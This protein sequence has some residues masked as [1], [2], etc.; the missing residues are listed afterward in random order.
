[1]DRPAQDEERLSAEVV[2]RG[3]GGAPHE[4]ISSSNLAR[5]RPG[6]P[7]SSRVREWFRRRGFDTTDV[8]G[9][10]FSVTGRRR[11]FEETWA[12]PLGGQGARPGVDVVALPTPADMPGDLAHDVVA[13]TFPPPPDFGPGSY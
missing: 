8:H 11:L 4:G 1:M 3:P 5:Y 10:S 6:Q 12:T 13:V 2:L 9:I 7:R